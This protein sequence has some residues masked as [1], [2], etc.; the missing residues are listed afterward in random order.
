[1]TC[2]LEIKRHFHFR[3]FIVSP[4]Y[5]LP[6]NLLPQTDSLEISVLPSREDEN[7]EVG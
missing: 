2:E 5:L 3:R 7:L 6:Q 1:M 4:H